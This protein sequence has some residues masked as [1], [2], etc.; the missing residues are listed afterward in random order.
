MDDPATSPALRACTAKIVSSYIGRN[1]TPMADL[2]VVITSV[3]NALSGLG[4]LAPIVDENR[5]PAVP[6]RRSVRPDSL[7][8]L[9][10][11]FK[12]KMLRRHLNTEHNL[13]ADQYRERWH[14]A[15]DYP[16]TAPN[17]SRQRSIFAKE[18]GLGRRSADIPVEQSE[19]QPQPEAAP[20]AAP[21]PQPQKRSPRVL[22]SQTSTAVVAEE[23]AP[24]RRGRPRKQAT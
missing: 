12:G 15:P 10:C 14:L 3:Y 11:G 24:R 2:P 5:E 7:I 8:C 19:V 21:E 1:N 9:E 16:V 23:E 6:I 4:Q 13:T 17:Y 22:Q 18:I 20:E